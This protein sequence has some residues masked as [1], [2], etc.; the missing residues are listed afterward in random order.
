MPKHEKTD[1]PARLLTRERILILLL[2]LS[3][4]AITASGQSV[5][6]SALSAFIAIGFALLVY[7]LLIRFVPVR[8]DDLK[9]H[10]GWRGTAIY[11][12]VIVMLILIAVWIGDFVRD[13]F[14]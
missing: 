8:I 3:G 1:R 13:T 5:L 9:K 12:A 7:V 4:A 2:V 14:Q 11:W 10:G 6:A